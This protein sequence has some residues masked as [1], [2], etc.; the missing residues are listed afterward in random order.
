MPKPILICAKPGDIA[1]RVIT[2]GDPERATQLAKILTNTRVVNTNRG[3][4]T[5]TGRYNGKQVTIATH[6]IGG[7]SASIVFEELAMLGARSMVRLGT[8]GAMI[9]GLNR[10]DIIIPTGAAHPGGSLRSY[11]PDGVL[12]PVADIGL[13]S[14]LIA[15]CKSQHLK[16]KTGL[17]F[18]SEAYYNED[19]S[20]LKKW[21]PMGVIGVDMECATLF[22][23][24]A[25]RRFMAASLLIVS[26]NLVVKKEKEMLGLQQ[27][28]NTV[29][30]AGKLVLNA[31][32]VEP[33]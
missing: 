28:K 32:T 18:S 23:L 29:E 26:D 3:Y 7:P 9:R 15:G 25:I 1:I 5:Y 13:T 4:I 2:V 14:K 19:P 21:V 11:V 30:K 17:I 8:A 12:P 31:L 20:F 16:F 22:T 27:L 24:G 33:A 6:G 10:G